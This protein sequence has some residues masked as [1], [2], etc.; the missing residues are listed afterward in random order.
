V[1]TVL[2]SNGDFVVSTEGATAH[3]ETT[4]PIV[5]LFS[6]AGVESTAFAATK[7]SFGGKAKGVGQVIAVQLNG[8]VVVGGIVND[9]SP[10]AGG[11]S[12]LDTNGDLDTTFGD[13]GTV[14]FDNSVNALLIEANGDIIAVETPDTN[15]GDGIVLQRYL[16][17]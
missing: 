16:A 7:I 10:I 9:A 2:E 5:S 17:N 15:G 1:P 4:F 12:R 14:T 11:L 8:Q 13:A 6:E 3:D